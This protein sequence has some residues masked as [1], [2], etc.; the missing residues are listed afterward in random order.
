MAEKDKRKSANTSIAGISAAAV[1]STAMI[2]ET[3]LKK[4]GDTPLSQIKGVESV[5]T[6]SPTWENRPKSN[7]VKWLMDKSGRTLDE[8]AMGLGCTTTYLNNKLHR[9]SFSMD[10]M[11]I[12]AYVCGYGVTF[13]SNNPEDKERS[14]YQIDVQDYFGASD[15]AALERLLKY[16][17]RLKIQKK[18]EYEELKAKLA[19]MKAEY[20][21]ED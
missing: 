19:Q 16:E 11:I 1:A 20:G 13:T 4:Y 18:D 10:D 3:L 8:V 2:V 15:P 12:V 6:V 9:D 21:F 14:T 7:I 5:E 17:K